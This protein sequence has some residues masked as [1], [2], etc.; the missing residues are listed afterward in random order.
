M[1]VV[2]RPLVLYTCYVPFKVNKS[3]F[4]VDNAFALLRR[5]VIDS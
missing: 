4:Y 1:M 3:F 2:V 5:H